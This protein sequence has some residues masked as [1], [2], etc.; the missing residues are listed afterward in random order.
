MSHI[1]DLPNCFP[2]VFTLCYYPSSA[3]KVEVKSGNVNRLKLS[4]FGTSILVVTLGTS[5][6]SRLEVHN[7]IWFHYDHAEFGHLFKQLTA[8]RVL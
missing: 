5:Y 4:I 6:V 8:R 2:V 7:V 3:G 1:L